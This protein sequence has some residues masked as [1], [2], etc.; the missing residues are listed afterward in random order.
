LLCVGSC[1]DLDVT[2]LRVSTLGP[3]L[4]HRRP[5]RPLL[6]ARSSQ[7]PSP[8]QAAVLARHG[9]RCL[10]PPAALPYTIYIYIY[11]Y[12]YIHTHTHTQTHTHTHTDTRELPKSGKTRF[13][14][15][16]CFGLFKSKPQG[17]RFKHPSAR[18]SMVPWLFL[19]SA[20]ALV[21]HVQIK[22]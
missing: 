10:L 22:V 20:K 19:F 3:S 12:I 17:S 9:T 11:I 2:R 13:S 5:P 21:S 18:F 8:A 6:F 7:V 1:N 16:D 14:G 4:F 15:L